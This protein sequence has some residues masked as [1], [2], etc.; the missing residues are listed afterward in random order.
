MALPYSFTSLF[1]A[2]N[3]DYTPIDTVL[4]FDQS[5]PTVS[6]GIPLTDDDFVEGDET[7]NV[8]LEILTQGNFLLFTPDTELVRIVD[9]DSKQ[10]STDYCMWPIASFVLF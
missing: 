8:H 6:T 10:Y 2:A 3:V 4:T 9:D 7:L 1:L 5:V